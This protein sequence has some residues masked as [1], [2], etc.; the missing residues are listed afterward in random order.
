MGF[1]LSENF[2]TDS[3]VAATYAKYLEANKIA[4]VYRGEG[5]HREIATSYAIHAAGLSE[6]F[7]FTPYLN[8][9]TASIG[10]GEKEVRVASNMMRA[11][12]NVW[13]GRAQTIGPDENGYRSLILES[14]N[15]SYPYASTDMNARGMG[16][17]VWNWSHDSV[18]TALY[19]PVH[20]DLGNSLFTFPEDFPVE[21]LTAS[22]MYSDE[23]DNLPWEKDLEPIEGHFARISKKFPGQ[24]SFYQT[25][26]RMKV[27]RRLCMKPGRYLTMFYPEMDANKVRYWAT[28]ATNFYTLQFADKADDIQAVYQRGPN[29]C[30]CHDMDYYESTQHPTRAYESPDLKLAYIGT[31]TRVTARALVWPEKKT[32]GRVY[33][34]ADRLVAL[35]KEAGYNFIAEESPGDCYHTFEGAR[36]TFIKEPGEDEL[37]ICPYIDGTNNAYYDGTWLV[38][39]DPPD[40][41]SYD[42]YECQSDSGHAQL[43]ART[44]V[45]DLDEYRSEAWVD[46]NCR[47]S[48]T[49]DE[50]NRYATMVIT[51]VRYR[52]GDTQR[53]DDWYGDHR[54]EESTWFC[55][56]DGYIYDNEVAAVT[57]NGFDIPLEFKDRYKEIYPQLK[58]DEDK[59]NAA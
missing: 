15:Y 33:G 19:N 56:I 47:Y 2:V 1:T 44:Y 57:I 51:S 18:S 41:K 58:E 6:D 20:K 35:L 5:K 48:N 29:S 50:Y 32:V 4:D 42:T 26:E 12:F 22:E 13:A 3:F 7:D 30:M 10:T 59:E 8:C 24:V 31:D 43:N 11:F 25:P 46:D 54:L 53:Y 45:A 36:I 23:Y 28:Q 17:P 40:D 16:T 49:F 52:W 34:D 55:E 39:G 9:L 21:V 14:L 38:I 27:G 37:I